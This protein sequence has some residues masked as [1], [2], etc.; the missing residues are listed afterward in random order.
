MKFVKVKR[1]SSGNI[2]VKELID[3]LSSLDQNKVIYVSANNGGHTYP[4]VMELK[5]EDIDTYYV[6]VSEA[7]RSFDTDIIE[8]FRV[9]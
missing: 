6:L 1:A 9:F 5:N 4:H 3:K 2:T 8:N 7:D